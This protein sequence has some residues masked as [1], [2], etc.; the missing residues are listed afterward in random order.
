MMDEHVD[1]HVS[2]MS[3]FSWMM[4]QALF[5]EEVLAFIIRSTF[6]A[7]PPYFRIYLKW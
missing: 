7:S 2:W 3:T 6:C 1:E 5:L 4:S